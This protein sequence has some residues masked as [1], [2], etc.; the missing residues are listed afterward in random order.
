MIVKIIFVIFVVIA[1]IAT[2]IHWGL[3]E[4]FK[5]GDL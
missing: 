1:V 3:K 4:E 2:L 5:R